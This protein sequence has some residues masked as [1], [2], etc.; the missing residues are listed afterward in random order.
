MA[1]STKIFYFPIRG[2]QQS[3]LTRIPHTVACKPRRRRRR[4]RRPPEALAENHLSLVAL[5]FA[6]TTSHFLLPRAGRAEPLRLALAAKGVEYE[7]VAV[8]YAE[9]KSDRGAYAFAQCPR[10]QD[11]C[12]N[13]CQSNA[14]L[15]HL[16][17]KHFPA[18]SL[19]EQ[20]GV[21]EVVEGVESIK[22]KYLSLIYTDNLS[23]EAKAAFWSTHCDPATAS[24][25][26]GGA[27]WAFLEGLV[28]RNG[29]SWAVGSDLTVADIEL[30]DM[31][32]G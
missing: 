20:A 24:A 16:Q 4:R 15:R 11:D 26:N 8:D 12:V 3:P 29:S 21:D 7:D 19:A 10:L 5:W 27:H 30:F 14:I 13:V 32:G 25:R 23:D 22:G 6:Q 2:T 28:Q 1:P 31:V 9:M 17:R 18:L